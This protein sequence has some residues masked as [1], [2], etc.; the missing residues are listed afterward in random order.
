[1]DQPSFLG[2][3][4][5][6]VSVSGRSGVGGGY[7]RRCAPGDVKTNDRRQLLADR[8]AY[9]AFLESQLQHNNEAFEMAREAHNEAES[10]GA[11]VHRISNRIGDVE[12]T[13]RTRLG[14]LEGKMQACTEVHEAL[15]NR[16]RITEDSM[17]RLGPRLERD[18]AEVRI[19]TEAEI[20]RTRNE[21]TLALQELSES[22]NE[23][24][25]SDKAKADE[26]ASRLMGEAQSTCARLADDA[27]AAAEASQIKLEDFSRQTESSFEML[28]VDVTAL[29]AELAGLQAAGPGSPA[30]DDSGLATAD[31]LERKVS[32]RLGQQVLQLS[33]VL[34]RVVQAQASMQRH[35]GRGHTPLED[36]AVCGSS[37]ASVE[38]STVT[39][40]DTCTGGGDQRR[41]AAIDDL[42]REL[43]HLEQSDGAVRRPRRASR[44]RPAA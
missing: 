44:P 24:L 15:G 21:T 12:Q 14:D 40:A 11:S 4:A 19:T 2:P 7:S 5:S 20:A 32:A 36:V 16:C 8:N 18:V 10:V 3:G 17:E 35:G 25:Q 26:T 41:R 43:R 23:R 33:D 34:R 1:M 9:I 31:L 39:S 30:D 28:R 29:R 37:G 22:F 38:G 27:L 42:Y 6:S 13:M